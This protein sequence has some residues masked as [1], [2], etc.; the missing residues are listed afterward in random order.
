MPFIHI[1]DENRKPTGHVHINFGPKGNRGFRHCV[2]CLRE[3]LLQHGGKLCDGKVARGTCDAPI[4]DFHATHVE[5]KDLDFC[6]NHRNQ[7]PRTLF[8]EVADGT[9]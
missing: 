8:D 3:K 6:P 4:C 9:L 7:A 5:G 1:L 2:F